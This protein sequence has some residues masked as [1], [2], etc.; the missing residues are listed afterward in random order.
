MISFGSN[1]RGHAQIPL[2]IDIVTEC[3]I[4]SLFRLGW[5]AR[6]LQRFVLS[7][8]GEIVKGGRQC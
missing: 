8:H 5:I 6:S 4:S 2:P 1:Y 7:I 3:G